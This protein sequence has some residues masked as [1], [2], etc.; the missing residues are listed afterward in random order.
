ML[1]TGTKMMVKTPPHHPRTH[2]RTLSASTVWLDATDCLRG[3][4]DQVKKDK[5]FDYLASGLPVLVNYPGWLAEI[6]NQHDCGW[7]VPPGDPE[8]FADVL[9]WA[10]DHRDSLE[11]Q[12]ERALAVGRSDFDLRRLGD[13][14]VDWL[15]GCP[16]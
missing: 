7:T 11:G 5:F 13:L 10:A 1:V 8:G 6:I 4:V 14:L 3:N 12:G 16:S 9:E 15:E 2:P